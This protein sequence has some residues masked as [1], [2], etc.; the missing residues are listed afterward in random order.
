MTR[1]IA[2][3]ALGVMVAALVYLDDQIAAAE[4][5]NSRYTRVFVISAGAFW[6]LMPMMLRQVQ[7]ATAPVAAPLMQ[8]RFDVA[9]APF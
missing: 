1:V 8:Q 2:A 3:V 6:F 9:P 5:R 7:G 4:H